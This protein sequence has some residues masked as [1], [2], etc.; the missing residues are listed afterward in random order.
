MTPTGSRY[1]IRK[2]KEKVSNIFNRIDKNTNFIKSKDWNRRY[3]ELV[4]HYEENGHS[5]VPE[6][7][8]GLETWVKLKR[9][10]FRDGILFEDRIC[11]LNEVHF[12]FSFRTLLS[13]EDSYNK[14]VEFSEEN[15]H[16]C[17][18]K[19]KL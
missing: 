12:M 19:S 16:I 8:G 13:W 14:L 9:A 3:D 7:L 2:W 18:L 5:N 11:K 17:I 10:K 6:T 1:N 4:D 15:G